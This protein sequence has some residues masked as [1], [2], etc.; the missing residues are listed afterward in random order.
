MAICPVCKK[1]SFTIEA[2]LI[3]KTPRQLTDKNKTTPK[4]EE[5]LMCDHCFEQ[6]KMDHTTF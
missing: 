6:Y 4:F 2:R 5:K 1:E 3:D